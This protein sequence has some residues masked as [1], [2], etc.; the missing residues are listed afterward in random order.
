MG[1][2]PCPIEFRRIETGWREVYCGSNVRTPANDLAGKG[3]L[4]ELC[5]RGTPGTPHGLVHLLMVGVTVA[6]CWVVSDQDVGAGG[7]CG[8]AIG[9]LINVGTREAVSVITMES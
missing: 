6:T 1:W 8:D 7:D 9:D 3:R 2:R 4:E 5:T